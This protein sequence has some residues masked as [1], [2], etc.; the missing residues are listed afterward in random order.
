MVKIRG[1][2]VWSVNIPV[3]F[4][5]IQEESEHQR[6]TDHHDMEFQQAQ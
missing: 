1:R 3:D 2:R 5:G 4:A 6:R